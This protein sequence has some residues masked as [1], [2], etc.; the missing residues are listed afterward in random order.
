MTPDNVNPEQNPVAEPY[1]PQN[2]T[3][4]TLQ[5]QTPVDPTVETQPPQANVQAEM[6]APQNNPMADPYVQ[7]AVPNLQQP[8]PK[9]SKKGLI[10]AIVVVVLLLLVGLIVAAVL[11]VSSA[12]KTAKDIDNNNSSDTKVSSASTKAVT[13]KYDSDFDI[14][15]QGGS[16]TNA[17]TAVKPY[18]IL[19]FAN[20]SKDK[21]SWSSVSAGYGESY[22]ADSDSVES[23]GVVACLDMVK[24][25]EAKTKTCDFE[26]AGKVTTLDLYAVKYSLTYY[27]AKTGKVLSKG[28][29]VNGPATKCP[30]FVSYD[31]SDPKIYADPDKNAVELLHAQF[32]K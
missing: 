23:V 28:E 29:T 14:V 13:A 7:P 32:A 24:G 4:P 30:Y 31:K 27:E 16:V 8:Q 1:N 6:G 12:T 17:P 19:T 3:A 5:P 20:N 22:Y 15:C 9:K 18:K 25:S 2:P 11:L 10:I 21:E 26:S